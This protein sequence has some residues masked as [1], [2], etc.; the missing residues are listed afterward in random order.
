MMISSW[1][2]STEAYSVRYQLLFSQT[3]DARSAKPRKK[4]EKK[5]HEHNDF[6]YKAATTPCLA[7]S[8]PVGYEHIQDTVHCVHRGYLECGW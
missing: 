8:H 7:D 3:L 6:T 1:C 5:I 2:L 4:K